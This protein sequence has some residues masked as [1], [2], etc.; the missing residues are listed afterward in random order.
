[1]DVHAYMRQLFLENFVSWTC[2]LV[3]VFNSIE[4]MSTVWSPTGASPRRLLVVILGRNA[5]HYATINGHPAICRR[6]LSL[7]LQPSVP[8]MDNYT[9]LLYAVLKSN[10]ECVRVL[11]DDGHAG[12]EAPT[13]A[14]HLIP[15]TIA[16]RVGDIE[17]VRLLLQHGARSIPDT[18]GEYPI[19]F[20]AQEG[21]AEICRLLYQ[22]EGWDAQDKYNEWTPLFHAARHGREECVYVLLELGSRVN[23]VD[24]TGKQALF[25]A[26]W[27][28]HPRCVDLLLASAAR[29]IQSTMGRPR[30]TP[31]ISPSVPNTTEFD[32]DLIPSLSL[33]PPIMPYRVYGHNFL[34]K[35][36][37]VH[38][39]V[40]HPFS[41][42]AKKH[43]AVNLSSRIVGPSD[44]H[45]LHMS[46][47]FKLV[48]N[49]KPDITAAPYSV[50]IPVRE[51]KDFFTF[52]T[53]N[54]EELSLE[55]SVYPSFGTKTIGRAVALSSMLRSNKSELTFTLPILDHH[56]HVIGEVCTTPPSM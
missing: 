10:I 13:T 8:D 26:A 54:I 53:T 9:P 35:A 28:G 39:S 52:Q 34:D 37:L 2:V 20:A 22:Y 21:H 5:L 46:P 14:V 16:C 25:Y 11:L 31:Q 42:M 55:F 30:L 41:S 50:F 4:S 38:V 51:E 33:P 24:E 47:L 44:A 12:L 18:N 32:I 6:L 17:V 3:K 48:M 40:G 36:C 29:T 7:G 56:L 27:Y 1:M 15:L 23:V 43:P 49:C 19:H 45:L